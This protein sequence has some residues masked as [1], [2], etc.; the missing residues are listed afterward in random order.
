MK[1]DVLTIAALVFIAGLVLSSVNFTE[2]FGSKAAS[3]GELSVA[4]DQVTPKRKVQH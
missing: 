4:F 3:E 1:T 2:I